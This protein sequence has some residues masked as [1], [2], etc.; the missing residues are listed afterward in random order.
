M[1]DL[2]DLVQQR[3]QETLAA[4]VNAARIKGGCQRQFVKSVTK[5]SRCTPCS[6]CR[7]D[8]LRVMPDHPRTTNQAFQG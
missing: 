3:Q 5:L 4:Q 1:P 6:L 2:M 7:C 8:P